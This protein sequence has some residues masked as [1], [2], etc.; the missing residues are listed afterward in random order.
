MIERW[1][2][3]EEI[4]KHLG[5]APITI[6][7]WV[8]K[9]NIPSHRVGKFWRFKATEVDEWVGEGKAEIVDQK[10]EGK[11]KQKIDIENMELGN[12]NG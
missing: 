10:S 7:R 1:L 12:A 11:S 4:A 5:I 2:N 8:E 6:Y 3:V 9:G